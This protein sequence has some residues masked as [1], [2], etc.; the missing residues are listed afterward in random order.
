MSPGAYRVS[1]DGSIRPGRNLD[2]FSGATRD[3]VAPEWW[4][5]N[6]DTTLVP[7]VKDCLEAEQDAAK[8]EAKQR[9]PPKKEENRGTRD[10]VPAA[11]QYSPCYH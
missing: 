6:I 4:L 2:E 1:G 5:G 10:A 8:A 3:L 11:F 7:L 9:S